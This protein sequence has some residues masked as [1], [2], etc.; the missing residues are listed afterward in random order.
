MTQERRS[1]LHY[2]LIL[3]GIG[4]FD[5]IN[6]QYKHE[7]HLTRLEPDFD[8]TKGEMH[9]NDTDQLKPINESKN[10][11]MASKFENKHEY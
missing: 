8:A 10:H 1:T 11:T 9:V 7:V 2:H 4:F 3:L 5:K 6:S